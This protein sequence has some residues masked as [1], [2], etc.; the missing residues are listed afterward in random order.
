MQTQTPS[1]QYAPVGGPSAGNSQQT[2][3]DVAGQA[4]EKASELAGQAQDKAQDLVGQARSQAR[5]QIDQRSN[6]AAEQINQQAGDLRTVSQTLREQ[7]KEGPA[8]AADQLAQYAERA[9]GYLQGASADKLL[10]DAEDLG[11]RQPWAA[12]G[13]GLALGLLAS[14]FLKAS[15]RERYSSRSS[16]GAA[17]GGP[18]GVGTAAGAGAGV[19]PSYGSVPATPAPLTPRPPAPAPEVPAVVVSETAGSP[20]GDTDGAGAAPGRPPG[21]R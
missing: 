19:T 9:G 6:Q 7:G 11:R 15:S 18:A 16:S 14:R 2:D 3:Q 21:V 17:Y 8:K 1:D 20:L 5:A 10:H 4:Q 12:A 13:A